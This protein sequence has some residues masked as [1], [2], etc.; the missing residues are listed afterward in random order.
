MN[1]LADVNLA[2]MG[3]PWAGIV[4]ALRMYLVD[5]WNEMMDE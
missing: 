1:M 5:K 4:M 2:E 3:R